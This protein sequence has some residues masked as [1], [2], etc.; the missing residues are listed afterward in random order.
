MCVRVCMCV[1][2]VRAHVPD[3]VN[4]LG[5]HACML[6]I[7]PC[8][9]KPRILEMILRSFGGE[10]EVV[11]KFSTSSISPNNETDHYLS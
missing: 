9:G 10:C 1:I 6:K 7:S 5:V 3:H 11:H 2:V 8:S 4:A